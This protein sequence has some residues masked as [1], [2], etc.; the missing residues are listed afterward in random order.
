MLGGTGALAMAAGLAAPAGGAIAPGPDASGAGR[1]RA[2]AR[3][4]AVAAGRAAATGIRWADCGPKEHLDPPVRCGTVTVPLDYARPRGRQL[5]LAVARR[6]A[7]GRAPGP[8]APGGRT[9]RTVRTPRQGALVFGAGGPGATGVYFPLMPDMA[10]F[11]RPVAAAYDLVGYAPRG[12]GGHAPLSCVDPREFAS[13][14]TQAPP[15]PSAAYRW[16]RYT[17]AK[18]YAEGCARRAGT[19]LRHYTTAANARDLDVLR[20]ALGERRLT[21]V[22]ASYGTYL[23][24]VYASLFPSHVR[25]MVFDS[26]VGPGPGALWYRAALAR[27]K[28]LQTRW[29]DFLSW[30]AAHDGRYHLGTTAAQVARRYERVRGELA[31]RP[32][33]GTVGPGQ[34]QAAFLKAAHYDDYWPVRAA[35]LSAYAQGDPGPLVRQAAPIGAAAAEQE[36]AQAVYTA[37]ECNDAPWPRSWRAWDRDAARLARTAPFATWDTVWTH[38]PCAHW[39]TPGRRPVDVHAGAGTLPSTLVLAA[40]RDAVTPYAGARELHRRLAGSVLVTELGAGSHII[41]GA[42]N[43]CVDTPVLTYLL[44]GRPPALDTA[45]A[46]HPPPRAF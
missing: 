15:R 26:P 30:V 14:P 17:Q 4:T 37:V 16:R 29:A 39:S 28:A 43:S 40:R 33:G 20:A 2:E 11:W 6:P 19:A 22:G 34:L 41:A 18:A 42:G 36:N 12:V 24:A 45:C 9:G 5:T 25:R 35:A 3:G 44:R 32:A 1:A 46:P 38:L 23:G 31:A 8:A 21:F 7:S 27:A 10:A 13:A